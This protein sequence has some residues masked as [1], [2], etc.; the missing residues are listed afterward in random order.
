MIDLLGTALTSLRITGTTLLHEEYA[1]PWAVAVPSAEALAA[2]LSLGSHARAVAFHLVRKG[3][4]TL[5]VSDRERYRVNAGEIA[6][7][8]GGTAHTMSDGP[9]VE[10]CPVERLIGTF[11]SERA[12]PSSID[13]TRLVCGAFVVEDVG[14]HPLLASLP[15]VLLAGSDGQAGSLLSNPIAELLVRELEEPGLGGSYAVGRLVE[16]LCLEALRIHLASSRPIVPGFLRGLTDSASSRAMR[17]IMERPGAP[18]SVSSLARSACLS[19]SR[20]AARFRES[21]GLSPMEFA[22]RWRMDLAARWLA[23]TDW[24]VGEIA[25]RVGYE[26]PAAFSRAFSR[27]AGRSPM[28]WRV[29]HQATNSPVEEQD[30]MHS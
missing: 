28:S 30:A 19:P 27:I 16:L 24:S 7:V 25:E 2:L 6:I 18:I 14:L 9:A 20:F 21:V 5:R 15:P 23:K 11:R 4:F 1:P 22:T 13:G 29:E 3:A 12:G 8:F 10:P 17:A 26:S